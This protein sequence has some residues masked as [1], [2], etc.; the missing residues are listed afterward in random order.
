VVAVALVVYCPLRVFWQ[1]LLVLHTQLPLALVVQ[2]LHRLRS[3]QTGLIL[4]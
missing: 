1:L 4:L 2:V 3:V